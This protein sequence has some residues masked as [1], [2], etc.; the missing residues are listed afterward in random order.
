[1]LLSELYQEEKTST[2]T[3]DGV[4]YSLNKVLK[5][6][7][8]KSVT[9]YDV[10]DLKWVLKHTTVERDRVEAADLSKPILVTKWEDKLVAID[11]AHR[12]TKAV[13]DDVKTLPGKLVSKADLKKAEI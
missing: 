7:D 4:E 3:H 12:L 5:L 2:F 8:D 9:D 6:V 10:S 13:E 11:G 1:M